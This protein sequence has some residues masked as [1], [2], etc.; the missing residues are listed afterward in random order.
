MKKIHI[1]F[2]V[3]ILGLLTSCLKDQEDVFD[4][5][6]AQ[7]AEEAIAADYKILTS[8][9]HGW[10]MQYYPSP[11]RTYGGYN[12]LMKFTADGKVT[13]ASDVYYPDA[14]AESFYKIT[15]SAGI[16]LSFDTYNEIFH[17]FST[18]DAPL[19]GDTG[20]GLEG[21]YDFEFIS[22]SA[23]KIVLKGKKSGNYA[24]MV[25]LKD[26]NWADYITK[27]GTIEEGMDFPKYTM[28]VGGTEVAIVK[29]E[30]NFEMTYST[31]TTDT[32]INVP[33]VVTDAG[34][35]FY[36]PITIEG[37][38]INGFS[39]VENTYDF[40]CS[41]DAGIVLNGIV[42]PLT[43]TFVN[44]DWYIAYSTAGV[45]AQPY[46]KKM[47]EGSATEKEVIVLLAFTNV[48]GYP[49]LYFRSGNYAG[50]F[51]FDYQFD[52]DDTITMYYNGKNDGG[53]APYYLQYCD[54]GYGLYVF[55][56]NAESPRT[57]KL[58]A[59]NLKSPSYITLTDVNEPTN[60]ITMFTQPISYPFN[61]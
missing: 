2:A 43:E 48:S 18:P 21:D 15:Q 19:G 37:K 9:E 46:L 8:A 6:S 44:S 49:S 34:I 53:N 57:F 29:A 54:Y 60:V 13:V 7:R 55:G 14:T 17:L 31:A 20:E 35:Q 39:Y 11:Y 27:I 23:E 38:E 3:A 52:G 59:D 32:T 22:A 1:I 40:P 12:V 4:K 50:Y 5:P 56:Y 28:T 58:S 33:Y 45:F 30:R 26:D 25:P 24:T 10:L 47:E 16:V 36:E 61:N 41:N 42:P 51:C